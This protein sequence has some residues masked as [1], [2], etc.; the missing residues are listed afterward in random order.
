MDIKDK[1]QEIYICVLKLYIESDNID[2]TG[3]LS[4]KLESIIDGLKYCIDEMN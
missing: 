4:D 1:L 2:T 3:K